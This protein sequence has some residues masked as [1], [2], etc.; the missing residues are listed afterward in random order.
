[1][2]AKN[3]LFRQSFGDL[4]VANQSA[5]RFSSLSPDSLPT[6]KEF[7]RDETRNYAKR[8]FRFVGPTICYAFMQAVEW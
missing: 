1:M 7:R 2:S 5:G 3:S 8:G 6:T 4:L